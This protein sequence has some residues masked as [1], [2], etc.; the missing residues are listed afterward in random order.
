MFVMGPITIRP[1]QHHLIANQFAAAEVASPVKWDKDLVG[2][3]GRKTPGGP[4]IA[5]QL[6]S[7][8][9]RHIGLVELRG[10]AKSKRR[11]WCAIWFSRNGSRF[12]LLHR[13]LILGAADHAVVTWPKVNVANGGMRGSSIWD[14]S[15]ARETE[16]PGLLPWS[17]CLQ[18]EI[19]TENNSVRKLRED[20]VQG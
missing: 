14:Y 4:A 8:T 11:Q 18:R 10:R 3:D 20:I 15:R 19:A 6:R 13:N 5:E 17:D 2:G 7:E 12:Q 9:F 16:G 1:H